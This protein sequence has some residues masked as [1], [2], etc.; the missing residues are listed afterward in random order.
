MTQDIYYDRSLRLW[1]LIMRDEQGNAIKGEDGY[2][3][4][5]YQ[6]KAQALKAV[7]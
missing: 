3:A 4:T 1:V 7:A 5:Y 2:E 6:T